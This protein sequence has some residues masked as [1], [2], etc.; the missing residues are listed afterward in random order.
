MGRVKSAARYSD[1]S[2]AALAASDAL[3]ASIVRQKARNFYYGMRLTPPDRRCHLYA[4]YAWMRYVDDEI[5]TAPDAAAREAALRRLCDN[6]HDALSSEPNSPTDS[7]FWPSFRSAVRSCPID[8]AWLLD[9]LRGMEEDVHHHGY[10]SIEQML[11]YCYR[12]GGTVG[13]TCM[14]IWGVQDDATRAGALTMA[15]AR[16]RAFQ[17]TNILRDIGVD[18]QGGDEETMP[19]CYVATE[20]LHQFDLG[21]EDL[22]R[23]ERPQAC[24][25]LIRTMCGLAR[26]EYEASVGL[27]HLV[28]PE[29]AG[30][31]WAMTRIYQRVLD[32][33]EANPMVCVRGRARLSTAAK[34]AVMV[35]AACGLWQR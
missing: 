4:C 13:E 16:G 2:A 26:R 1:V 6:T 7:G 11:G 27:E 24:E 21:L 32:Q 33:I 9:M 14:A 30:S 29:C 35:Q 10:E 15:A 8:P 25:A 31:L 17:L 19:R 34:V 23:W 3:C 18:A 28:V 12:V 22:V 5:D 20:M